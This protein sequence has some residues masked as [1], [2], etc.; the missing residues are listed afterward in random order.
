MK[1]DASISI[2]GNVGKDAVL[3]FTQAGKAVTSFSVAVYAGKDFPPQWFS[4][5]AWEALAEV[6]RELCAKGRK[7]EVAGYLSS[8]RWKDKNGEEKVSVELIAQQIHKAEVK[9]AAP[10]PVDD[11][12]YGPPPLTDSELPF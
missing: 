7:V 6:A 12:N 4:V 3:R 5:V 1:K 10:K 2:I 11:F 8:R 9:Q